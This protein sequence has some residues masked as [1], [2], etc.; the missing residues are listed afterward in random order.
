MNNIEREKHTFITKIDPQDLQRLKQA[1]H[2]SFILWIRLHA[3]FLIK[4]I[5]TT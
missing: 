4:T 2:R 5:K 1:G 3:Q